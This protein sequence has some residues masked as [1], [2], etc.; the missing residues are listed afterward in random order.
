VAGTLGL[1]LMQVEEKQQTVTA[2]M[3][4]DDLNPRLSPERADA[5]RQYIVAN[6]PNA[7]SRIETKGYGESSPPGEQ[8]LGRGTRQ[9]LPHRQVAD[10]P[11]RR[12]NLWVIPR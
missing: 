9:E 6:M 7:A 12:W 3:G 4:D 1:A 8:P 11:L 5:L 10:Q 2:A